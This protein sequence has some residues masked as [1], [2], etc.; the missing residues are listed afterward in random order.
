MNHDI[1]RWPTIDEGQFFERKSAFDRSAGRPK[2]R[3]AA[4]IA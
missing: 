4:D 3:K 2:H 1:H